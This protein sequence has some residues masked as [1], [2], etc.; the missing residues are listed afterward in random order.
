MNNNVIEQIIKKNNK[1]EQ[2]MIN[3][4]K[5]NSEPNIITQN[6]KISPF[7]EII[8]SSRLD[9]NII[10]ITQNSCDYYNKEESKENNEIENKKEK[11][12]QSKSRESLYKDILTEEPMTFNPKIKYNI[13]NKFPTYK[14]IN[15]IFIMLTV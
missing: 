5:N 11:I 1:I 9:D 6:K 7:I 2:N 3:N 15:L 14:Y 4:E 10:N 12:T 13:L 8:D